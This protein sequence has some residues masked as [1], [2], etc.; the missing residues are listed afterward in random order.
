MILLKYIPEDGTFKTFYLQRHAFKAQHSYSFCYAIAYE[1][2]HPC[3]KTKTIV[4]TLQLFQATHVIRFYSLAFI[5]IFII[6]VGSALALQFKHIPER[7]KKYALKATTMTFW[8]EIRK[9]Y[10]RLTALCYLANEPI[11][12]LIFLSFANNFHTILFK[13]FHSIE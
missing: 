1:V 13:I 5:D 6:I 3:I 7:L 11:S 4:S 10:T 2:T 9:D 12:L 8:S